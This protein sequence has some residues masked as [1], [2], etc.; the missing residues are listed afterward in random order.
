MKIFGL[1]K[2]Q[3]IVNCAM[4]AKVYNQCGFGL[5]LD[6]WKTKKTNS[7]LVEYWFDWHISIYSCALGSFASSPPG[8][9]WE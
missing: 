9:K 3:S 5:K 1:L 8:L 6:M 7:C 4:V 2:L